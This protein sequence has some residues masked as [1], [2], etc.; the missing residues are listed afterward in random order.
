M[1]PALPVPIPEYEVTNLNNLRA[2]L[3]NTGDT[4]DLAEPLWESKWGPGVGLE[5]P[6][7]NAGF[8]ARHL[9]IDGGSERCSQL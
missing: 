6:D 8:V 3:A 9:L 2:A 1:T 7:L 5:R 4:A